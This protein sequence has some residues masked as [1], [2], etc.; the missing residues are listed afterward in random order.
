MYFIGIITQNKATIQEIVDHFLSKEK[1]SILF[2]CQS[3]R[4]YRVLPVQNRKRA[5]IVFLDTGE[6]YFELVQQL[7]YLRSINF[8]YHIVLLSSPQP[9]RAGTI[10]FIDKNHVRH[11][12][13]NCFRGEIQWRVEESRNNHVP[14]PEPEPINP[15]LTHRETEIAELVLKGYTNKKIGAA[16]YISTC[17]VN[18]HMRKIFSKLSVKSRTELVYKMI[19]Q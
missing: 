4:D 9:P 10:G 13:E 15:L 19:N 12:L 5:Q 17:T 14:R 11:A 1:F 3:M 16:L 2:I 18:A 6:N 7:K 8:Q